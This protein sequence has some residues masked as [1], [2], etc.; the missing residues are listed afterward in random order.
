MTITA[1]EKERFSLSAFLIRDAPARFLL[2]WV[3][4]F[5]DTAAFI[6]LF[7]IFTAHVTGNIAL[8]GSAFASSDPQT[9]LL[10]L[11]ML[12][13]FMLSVAF[14]S[15]LA[16]FAR[17]IGW[18]VLPVLLSAEAI[19]LG[20]FM[21]V[22]LQFS[23]TL[24]VDVQ[25]ELIFPI[26]VTG[27][28][29]MG[30]QNAL[31]KEAAASF[32]GYFPTTVMTGNFTQFTIDLVHYISAKFVKQT[33]ETKSE[34]AEAMRKLKLT[35]PLLTGFFLGGTGAAYFVPSAEFWCL[36]MPLFAVSLL[37]VAAYIQAGVT[38]TV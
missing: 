11:S 35:L 15:L 1:P 16:N 7:G 34:A 13:V 31:M 25:D 24:L 5:V 2:S 18:A 38:K 33:E 22:G 30:I 32:T 29:A 9:T 23:A 37:A 3:A 8:A 27:V 20:I 28:M 6:V 4:G 10:R 36:S 19:A 14:T 21:V 17:K 12:P 26:A